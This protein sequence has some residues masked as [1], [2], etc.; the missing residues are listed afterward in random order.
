MLISTPVTAPND[1]PMPWLADANVPLGDLRYLRQMAALRGPQ[2]EHPCPRI[3]RI[4]A[5]YYQQMAD[6]AQSEV[7][8]ASLE[9]KAICDAAREG[10]L[11]MI[12]A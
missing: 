12:M 4:C 5:S 3:K 8:S 2:S 1:Q 7:Q 6:Q 10:T 9:T 11:A